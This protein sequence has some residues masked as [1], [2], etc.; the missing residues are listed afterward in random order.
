MPAAARVSERHRAVNREGRSPYHG[1]RGVF[2]TVARRP[3]R[4]GL[5]PD[6]RGSVAGSTRPLV[7]AKASKGPSESERVVRA[8]EK[9]GLSPRLY[10]PLLRDRVQHDT[11]EC[12]K[13]RT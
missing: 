7:R 2:L 9:G 5:P 8:G 13:N 10:C 1:Y 3:A 12:D 6:S 11:T 4:R